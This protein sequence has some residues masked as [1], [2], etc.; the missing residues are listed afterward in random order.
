[1]GKWR[2]VLGSLVKR[3]PNAPVALEEREGKSCLGYGFDLLQN[4]GTRDF[5]WSRRFFGFFVEDAPLR[6]VTLVL[7]SDHETKLS[8]SINDIAVETGMLK[9]GEQVIAV[10]PPRDASAVVA[11]VAFTLEHTWRAPDDPRKL[12]VR[13]LVLRVST[14]REVVC[15]PAAS[16]PCGPVDFDASPNA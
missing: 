13:L 7:G 9:V 12:G 11:H 1:M 14:D 10:R 3:R 2:Q 8:V 16:K 6:K 5:R 15:Y 4:D